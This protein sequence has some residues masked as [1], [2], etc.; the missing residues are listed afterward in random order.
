MGAVHVRIVSQKAGEGL[1]T[2]IE[3]DKVG[4]AI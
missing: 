2:W 3:G 1:A 4:W